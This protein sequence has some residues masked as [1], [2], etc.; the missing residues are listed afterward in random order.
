[1][2]E[3]YSQEI[4]QDEE[5]LRNYKAEELQRMLALKEQ[6]PD[7]TNFAETHQSKDSELSDNQLSS[8][9][10]PKGDESA[11]LAEESRFP[12]PFKR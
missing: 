3:E 5:A 8:S 11:K 4:A 2:T 12:N 9:P 1:M 7:I 10:I 6:Y